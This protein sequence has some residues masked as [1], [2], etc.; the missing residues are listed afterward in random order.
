MYL[1]PR[2]W[3]RLFWLSLSYSE[4]GLRPGGQQWQQKCQLEGCWNHL[5]CLM[6]L[7][8]EWPQWRWLKSGW[9]KLYLETEV[10]GCVDAGDMGMK[11]R[12][13]GVL[14]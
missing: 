7:R 14:N 1:L 12:N 13:E 8:P 3:L 2:S 4:N 11:G 6:W 5:G 9:N 10:I